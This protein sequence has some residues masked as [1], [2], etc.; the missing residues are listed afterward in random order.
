MRTVARVLGTTPSTLTAWIR[1]QDQESGPSERP[2]RREAIGTA[3]R[4][5]IRACYGKHYGQWGPQVLRAWCVR[6]GLGSWSA[7]TIAAVIADLRE[8]DQPTP[9]PLQLEVMAPDVMWS[10]DGTGLRHHGRKRELLV[11]QDECARLKLNWRVVDGPAAS[12]DVVSYLEEAFA[13]SGPPLVLKHDGDAIFHD[14][15][16]TALLE[17]HGVV[18]LTSPPGW[19]GYNGKQERS[20][21]DV[22][23]HERALRRH[24]VKGSLAHRLDLTMKD[25]NDDRPRP[26]LRG[27]TAREVYA[28]RTVPL[29][30]RQAFIAAVGKEEARLRAAASSRTEAASARRRA[31]ENTLIGDGLMVITRCVSHD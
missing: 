6:Q 4:A 11:V 24:G 25:L 8:A 14:R 21:R 13:R 23:S 16:V 30:N 5:R 12:R 18:A 10:E 22:K 1:R 19:P 28:D 3:A 15:R 7:T 9:G 29:P 27:R 20:M 17:R 2:G 26:V 31:I